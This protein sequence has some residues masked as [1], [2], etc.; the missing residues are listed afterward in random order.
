[1]SE[2]VVTHGETVAALHVLHDQFP[3]GAAQINHINNYTSQLA[4]TS[5]SFFYHLPAG[6]L[7]KARHGGHCSVVPEVLGFPR[8][9]ED[10]HQFVHRYRSGETPY[11]HLEQTETTH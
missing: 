7:V 3:L 10:R 4:S 11:S 2:E 5:S 1:M 6:Q 9:G 8:D